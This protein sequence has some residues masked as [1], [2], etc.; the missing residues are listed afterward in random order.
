[1]IIYGIVTF[2][3]W[4]FMLEPP[5]YVYRPDVS[6]AVA[7][8]KKFH[9]AYDAKIRDFLEG[10]PEVV[11]WSADS[12]GFALLTFRRKDGCKVSKGC[13]VLDEEGE[14]A[15]FLGETG[16]LKRET[17]TVPVAERVAQITGFF[18]D[19]KNASRYCEQVASTLLEDGE[20]LFDAPYGFKMKKK[21]FEG[22]YHSEEWLEAWILALKE[23]FQL[24]EAAAD[25]KAGIGC[26]RLKAL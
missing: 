26:F 19:D 15:E 16:T 12:L 14:I 8:R 20:C 5:R 17:L 9:E 4:L 23:E 22:H 6:E 21:E 25:E 24:R 1:M 10:H 2:I 11:S 7:E 3:K 13:F 18:K